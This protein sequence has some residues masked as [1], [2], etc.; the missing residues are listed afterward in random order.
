MKQGGWRRRPRSRRAR[1][2]F[3]PGRGPGLVARAGPAGRGGWPWWPGWP[4]RAPGASEAGGRDSGGTELRPDPRESLYGPHRAQPFSR[5]GLETRFSPRT[6]SNRLDA[7]RADPRRPGAP[8]AALD[9]PASPVAARPRAAAVR[10][11]ARAIVAAFGPPNEASCPVSSSS[12]WTPR[13]RPA[14][15]I[16]RTRH[17]NRH[18][19]RCRQRH[20]PSPQGP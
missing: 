18:H 1:R 13:G 7:R 17:R 11:V 8:G 5:R 14:S 15:T 10:P 2:A 4:W 20:C 6:G 12:T 9:G 19:R 3:G 16:Q